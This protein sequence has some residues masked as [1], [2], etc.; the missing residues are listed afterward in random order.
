M[1]PVPHLSRSVKGLT[2]LVTGAAS[3]MG[4]ATAF[5]FAREGA[6][7]AVTDRELAPSEAVAAEIRA[8]G[9]SAQAGVGARRVERRDHR[10]R[11]PQIAE[12]FGGLDAVVN[13][14]GVSR[15]PAARSMRRT[16]RRCWAGQVDGDPD[17]RPSPHHHAPALPHLRKS[18]EPAHRQHRL[19]RGA[20]RDGA[21]F[22]LRRRQS[23]RHRADPRARGRAR[24]GRHHRQLH[25]PRAD[26][27]RHDPAAIPEADKTTFA[28]RLHGRL[29][30]YVRR[31]PEEVA[32]I[33]LSLC[34]LPAASLHHRGHHPGGRRSLMARNA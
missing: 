8:E 24:Q 23:G 15:L 32:H 5:V 21:G 10:Q 18:Q 4:R 12:H 19:H 22:G 14:A 28:H 29:R 6:N 13:N 3:G 7:V 11:E 31:K 20:R 25:L 2:V 26:Q 34:L 17:H 9:G 33:T 30:R 16:T 27:D 1:E